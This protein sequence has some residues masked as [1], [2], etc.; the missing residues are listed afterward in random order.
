[1]YASGASV[2]CPGHYQPGD[3]RTGPCRHKWGRSGPGT[4][5]WV[6]VKRIG[7]DRAPG[8]TL[9]LGCP[10]CRCPIEFLTVTAEAA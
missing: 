3:R 1:V 9:I 6:R 8:L 10:E 4:E 7:H 2:V 5:T